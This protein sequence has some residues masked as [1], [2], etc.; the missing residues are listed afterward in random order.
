MSGIVTKRINTIRKEKEESYNVEDKYI[1]RYSFKHTGKFKCAYGV[2][3]R[4][5]WFIPLED[6]GTINEKKYMAH[7][8][9]PGDKS[10]VYLDERDDIKAASILKEPL[11]ARIRSLEKQLEGL[12]EKQEYLND[13]ITKGGTIDEGL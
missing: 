2:I 8:K 3:K 13:I 4:G 10:I 1:W 9:Y 12:K 6:D 5:L 7:Y 11:D